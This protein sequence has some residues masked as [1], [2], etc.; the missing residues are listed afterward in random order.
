MYLSKMKKLIIILISIIL[1]SYSIKINAN[2]EQPELIK[3]RSTAYIL[4]GKTSSGQ[5]VREGI[6]A[7]GNPSYFGKTIIVYQRLPHNKLG[8]C[9]GIFEAL[10]TGCNEYV[11]DV[12]F[13]T[14]DEAQNWMDKVYDNN[15]NGKIFIQVLDAKG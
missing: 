4:K 11:I 15:C 6:C 3:M 8:K 5:E 14:L 12:W 9:L 10:D 7:V 13:E 1:I 2:I